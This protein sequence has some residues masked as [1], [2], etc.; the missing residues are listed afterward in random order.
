DVAERAALDLL[1]RVLGQEAPV[2]HE[3]EGRVRVA[4]DVERAQELPRVWVR[5]RLAAEQRQGLERRQEA[6]QL[7]PDLFGQV[8]PRRAPVVAH[9]AVV[10]AVRARAD[11]DAE[12]QGL[13]HFLTLGDLVRE[14]ELV[15]D[16]DV[17]AALDP[18]ATLL[19]ATVV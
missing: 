6:R 13:E 2:R 9:D 12:R 4:L 18:E 14:E 3:V 11:R 19:E 15:L 5:E 16:E 17:G 1:Q 8:A 7:L 10:V